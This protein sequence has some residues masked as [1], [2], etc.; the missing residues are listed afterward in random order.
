M[1]AGQI[2]GPL[3][4]IDYVQQ[5]GEMGRARGQQNRLAQLA[6]Q[7]YTAPPEQ[8]TS[9]LGQMAAVDP[10]AAAAQ[11]GQLQN[12]QVFAQ[13]QEDRRL[14]KL[15]GA[16]RYLEQARQTGDTQKVQGA[17]RAVRPMLA[18]EIPDGQFPEQWD[19]ATMAPTLYEVL[20]KTG[21]TAQGN[22]Q[23]VR[24]GEDGFYYNVMRD[25]RV[26]NT[27]VKSSPTIKVLEQE[28]Q[29]PLGVVTS[30]GVAGQTVP[31]GGAGQ[32]A[33]Q[34]AQAQ[35]PGAYIDPSLP[36]EVQAQIRQ[37]LAAGQEPPAQ[38]V[39]GGQPS[40][41]GLA[42][43][44]TSAEKVAAEAAARRQ[45]ELS[46]LPAELGMRAQAA[47]AQAAGTEQA[48]GRVEQQLEAQ[49]ALPRVIQT[50]DQ[51]ISLIDQALQHP[52]RGTATGASGTLDPRNYVPGTDARDFQVL[53][54]QIKGG[55]FLQ[56][57]QSLRGGGAITEVEGKKA[58][59][60]IARLNTAQSDEAFA[61]S[62]QDL[63]EV[64]N[65]A[66][67]TAIRRASQG[68]LQS[69]PAA[70]TRR[71]VNPQTGQALVLRNGQWVPE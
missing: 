39:F 22:V 25:G 50:S 67:Q 43:T 31:L 41:G 65:I 51:A 16:A 3:D 35:P 4:A 36:P 58:E 11:Q 66:K 1:M 18:Q 17:W 45:V 47:I 37:S 10:R 30:G 33:A 57:F 59:Q 32:P 28:G 19:D 24:I 52:G 14:Q 68:Q 13:G 8:Q 9:I 46:T 61:K 69:A 2:F 26:V 70:A 49:Q 48:K 62:L 53:L 6:S 7:A 63:R 54:D 27:G 71:A 20:A 15:S 55:T 42:R 29:V 56:A 21:G 12:Q 44:P 60:A 64:A 38:M 5:Q 40:G 34:G 23:S